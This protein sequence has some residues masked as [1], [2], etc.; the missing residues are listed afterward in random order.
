MR[1]LKNDFLTTSTIVA[2]CISLIILITL[3]VFIFKNGLPSL[4]W[5]MITGDF[6][7]ET[8]NL[9]LDE[10]Y[11]SQ[12]FSRP[13]N[14]DGYFSSTWGVTFQDSFDHERNPVVIVTYLDP[15]SPL[16]NMKDANTNTYVG[17]FTGIA[18]RRILLETNTGELVVGLSKVK[19]E[20]MAAIFDQGVV[21]TDLVAF[22]PGGG[23]RGSLITTLLLIIITLIIAL[24]IGISA[25]IYIHE[26]APFHSTTHLFKRFIDATNGIPSIIFGMVGATVFIPMMSQVTKVNTGSILTGALTLTMMLLPIIIRAVEET[27]DAIPKSYREASF[28][29]GASK[30]QTIFKVILPNAISGILTATMLSIGRIIGESAAL[31]YAV[32]TII[33][34]Q[35]S[36][37]ERSTS[38]AVHIW[39][40]MGGE[41]PNFESAC[42]ISI[43]ILIIVFVLS[44]SVKLLTRK[45][46][47]NGET[48]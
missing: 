13:T 36:L 5:D 12:T 38:L 1:R 44:L 32:G 4:S 10:E 28:A 27:L 30:T 17:L 26:I 2:S 45:I 16:H 39:T 34:D 8:Y 48:A 15:H 9:S 43:I 20:S 14:Q 29:L 19:A 21:I 35:V 37:S 31:I 18:I 25:A 42:A 11:L 3:V 47:K 41:N 7:E 23:I 22:T 46:R 24:P 6:Y 40:L 33:K